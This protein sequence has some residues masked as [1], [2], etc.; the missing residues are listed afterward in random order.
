MTDGAIIGVVMAL[1]ALVS[2]MIGI[3]WKMWN[4]HTELSRGVLEVV[5][6]NTAATVEQTN[7][8]QKLSIAVEKNTEVTVKQKDVLT[9][10]AMD[11]LRLNKR[12]DDP[13]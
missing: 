13:A 12:H 7:S 6:Q 10:L 2:T 11:A 3:F 5:K 1:I 8:N 4:S 9:K